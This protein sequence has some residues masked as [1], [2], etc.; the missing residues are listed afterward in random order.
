MKQNTI[1]IKKTIPH[2]VKVIDPEK[3]RDVVYRE[4]QSDTLAKGEEKKRVGVIIF[5][6]LLG[7]LVV[8][9]VFYKG[10]KPERH[11]VTLPANKHASSPVTTLTNMVTTTA[12]EKTM[13]QDQ[14]KGFAGHRPVKTGDFVTYKEER[15]KNNLEGNLKK[16][17]DYATPLLVV[18]DKGALLSGTSSLSK[19]PIPR[20]AYIRVTLD[21]DITSQNLDIPVTATAFVDLNYNGNVLIPKDSKLVGKAYIEKDSR[22]LGVYFNVAIFPSGREYN[23]KGMALGEDNVTGLA[24]ETNYKLAQKSSSVVASS[25]LS[26]ASNS[27]TLPG[28][29]FGGLFAG[30]LADNAS[31]SLENAM[32][33]KDQFNHMTFAVMGGMR[34]KVVFF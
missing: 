26:A 9:F 29:S 33:Y 22:R 19:L 15:Q 27:L 25:L 13:V 17:R 24:V 12:L 21:R 1:I 4:H 14:N 16:D 18:A 5:M 6:I 23:I 31:N 20:D 30:E 11:R 34:F 8:Y 3:I 32:D 2:H 10:A 7:F 28:N